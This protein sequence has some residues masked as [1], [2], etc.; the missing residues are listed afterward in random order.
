MN[1]DLDSDSPGRSDSPDGTKSMTT[2][3]VM[4][5]GNSTIVTSSNANMLPG[6]DDSE[7]GN[8]VFTDGHPNEI[9][10]AS[11]SISRYVLLF[12]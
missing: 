4:S 1:A 11:S 12:V 5:G 8:E 2:N 9:P 7:N 3:S 6:M 10:S